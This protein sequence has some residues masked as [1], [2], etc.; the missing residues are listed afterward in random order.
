[1]NKFSPMKGIL[2]FW[3][4]EGLSTLPRLAFFPAQTQVKG[5]G[6]KSDERRGATARLLGAHLEST[7]L[8]CPCAKRDSQRYHLV[9]RNNK[10]RRGKMAVESGTTSHSET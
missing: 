1:M 7:R 4:P 6:G 5:H 2:K 8:V 9:Q 10:R 3:E